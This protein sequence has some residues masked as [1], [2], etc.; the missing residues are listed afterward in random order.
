MLF[1]ST[2]AGAGAIAGN[3]MGAVFR[4]FP[5]FS[6]TR[7][8]AHKHF[9]GIIDANCQHY[10]I[11]LCRFYAPKSRAGRRLESWESIEKLSSFVFKDSLLLPG[12]STLR[13]L[14]D[15]APTVGSL[16]P[17]SLMSWKP[18]STTAE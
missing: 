1:H 8:S 7:D 9:V 2:F 15:A 13:H 12:I 10:I 11:G 6:A 18:L 5:A 14:S 16:G 3:V 4:D 17:S